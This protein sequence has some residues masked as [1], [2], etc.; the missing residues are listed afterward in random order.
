MKNM[1]GNCKFAEFKKTEKGNI[2]KGHSGECTYKIKVPKLPLSFTQSFGYSDNLWESKNR[3]W[4][5][6]KDCEVFEPK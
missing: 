1:C 5:D 3:I 6:Y 2:K 4:Y